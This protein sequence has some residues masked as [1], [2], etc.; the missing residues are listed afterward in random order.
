MR[1]IISWIF[2]VFITQACNAQNTIQKDWHSDLDYMAKELPQ[3]HYDL[4]DVK[5]KDYFLQG[6]KNIKT[7]STDLSNLEIA[8]QL[9]QLIA[10]MLTIQQNILSE[11][12][13]I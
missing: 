10:S 13:L 4:F 7:S 12:T 9:Q 11:L 1:N 2:A 3:K 6:I 5:S 8:I